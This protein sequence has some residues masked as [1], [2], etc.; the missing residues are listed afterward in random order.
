LSGSTRPRLEPGG[1]VGGTGYDECDV[2]KQDQ[3]SDSEL[4]ARFEA[5]ALPL[6]PSMYSAAFRLT[7]N[8]SDAEDLIQETFLR[9]Y[10][11]FHQ[12]E[13]GTNLKAWLYRILMNTFINSYRR[14][15][16]QPQT[17]SDE[18]VA[19]WYLYS[20]MAENG[21]EPSAEASVIESLPDEDVQAALSSLP[22]Q[23]RVAV[24]LADVEGFSYKEIAD[25]TGVPIG[26]VM[27]RLHR[28]RKALEKRLW[29]VVKERGL[30]RD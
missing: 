23:F 25:I 6:L 20:K 29:D 4:R 1:R 18:E 19:D 8:A 3:A 9:A 27:S 16:R 28:G 21:M 26:T 15:Q 11:G 2:V 5:E 7:H 22:E 24:L 30:V 12:F 10:R 14:K 17:V 13:Q